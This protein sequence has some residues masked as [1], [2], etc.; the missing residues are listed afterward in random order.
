MGL[1]LWIASTA[2]NGPPLVVWHI[3]SYSFLHRVCPGVLAL[4]PMQFRV[5]GH[6]E[7]Q[8]VLTAALGV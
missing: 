5:P 3:G 1:V 6:L 8:V 2:G 4:L 7:P